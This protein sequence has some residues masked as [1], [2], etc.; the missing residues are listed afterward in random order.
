MGDRTPNWGIEP[1]PERLRVLGFVDLFLLWSSLSVSLLVIVA[2]AVL[3][4]GDFGLGLSLRSALVAIVAA[5][6]AGNLLLG[7]A[8]AIGADARVPGMVVLRAPLGHRGSYL[9]TFLNVVQNLGWSIFELLIIATA[10]AA[11]SDRVLGF[12]ARWLWTLLFGG[13][14][15]ALA[16]LGPIGFVRRYVRKFAI[17]VVL[18]SLLYLTWW[19]LDRSSLSEFW[20]DHGHD[21]STWAGF[22]L[23]LASII[24]WTPLAADYT[25]FGRNRRSA[26]WG[27][28]L[29]YFVPTIWMFGLG[30]LLLLARNINDAA[31]IPAAVATGGVLSVVALL[32]LTVDETDEAFADI[33]STA[34]S[35]QNIFPRLPQRFLIALV[36]ATA[37]AGALVLDLRNYQTFLFLLGS[38]FVP[39]LGVLIADWLLAGL[40]YDRRAIF[41]GPSVRVAQ[42]V[43]WLAGFAVYQWLLP[44]GPSWWLDLIHHTK[45]PV[46]FSA[47][48]PSFAT[49]FLLALL[50]GSIVSA[51]AGDRRSREPLPR[52]R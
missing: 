2:G 35:I 7:I 40:H 26:F 14:S 24:S 4:D 34:V 23:V 10:A 50:A 31:A 48:L 47:S 13:I 17:W 39:L 18:A 44:Q 42:I 8:G 41:E 38:F 19:V 29:G 3:V 16:L 37:T 22:D 9:P 21:G 27:T 49:A 20:H 46:D 36:A 51:R 33:Y 6:L 52:P 30:A 15:V 1:V 45:G 25:R 43:A 28:G 11:L 5:A 32:A 12:H